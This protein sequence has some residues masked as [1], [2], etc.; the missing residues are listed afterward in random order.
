M[1]P[2]KVDQKKLNEAISRMRKLGYFDLSIKEFVKYGRVM[3]N[4]P[5]VGCHYYADDDV[6]LQ[7]AIEKFEREHRALVYAVIRSWTNIG[8]MDSLLYVSDYPE[9][10]RYD[11]QDLDQGFT[12]AYVINWTY[13]DCSE[14]GSI[15]FRKTGAG[16][17]LRTF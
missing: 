12:V 5:P 4:E 15:G 16:G 17:L 9:D 14:L 8:D 10:W 1:D 2:M 6:Q 7:M 13:P 11:R 3:I